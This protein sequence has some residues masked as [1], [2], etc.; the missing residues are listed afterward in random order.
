MQAQIV[1]KISEIFSKN[2]PNPK[3]ELIYKND[4]T[5]L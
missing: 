1:N 3:T 4:F 2:N 5:L